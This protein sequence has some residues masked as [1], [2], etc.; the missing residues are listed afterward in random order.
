MRNLKIEVCW[1]HENEVKIQ[2]I[3]KNFYIPQA[4][5]LPLGYSPADPRTVMGGPSGVGSQYVIIPPGQQ[6]PATTH[7][8][9]QIFTTFYRP[10]MPV[11]KC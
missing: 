1:H 11:S 6:N 4:L 10:S 3:K 9:P 8:Q 2:N 7:A 5:N